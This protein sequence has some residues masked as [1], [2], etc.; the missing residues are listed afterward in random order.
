VTRATQEL[1]AG[2][3]A[4]VLG[5]MI[6]FMDTR[7]NWDDTGVT[8]GA[9]LLSAAIAAALGLRWWASALLVSFP[10]VLLEHR[11]AGWGVLLILAFA[12]AGSAL[13]AVFRSMHGSQRAH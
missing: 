13:G 1:L 5:S 11:S 6:A 12:V 8:A 4:L 10:I 9:L 3:S 7:P 2:V